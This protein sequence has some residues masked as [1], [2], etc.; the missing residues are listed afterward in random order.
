MNRISPLFQKIIIL[1]SLICF[2]I[3]WGGTF[4]IA[5]KDF[6]TQLLPSG[7]RVLL[8]VL[9]VILLL[10]ALLT[11][12][13]HFDSCSDGRLLC[14]SIIMFAA[15]III[16]LVLIHEFRIIPIND[17]HSIMD[18]A[19][20]MARSGEKPMSTESIYTNYFSKYS[21][22][23][24][25]ALF[26]MGI[27]RTMDQIGVTD[28]YSPLILLNMFFILSGILFTWLIARKTFGLRAAAK[29][30]LLCM[31]NPVY[32]L[33]VFWVYSNTLSIPFMM[34]LIYIALCLYSAKNFPARCI[35]CIAGAIITV[36]GFK[37]RPTTVI[38]VIALIVCFLFYILK[39]RKELFQWIGVF[40]IGLAAAGLLYIGIGKMCD[41]YFYTVSEGN[42]PITH[43]LMMG[44]HDEGRYNLS[45]DS[46]T[47]SLKTAEEK[48]EATLSRTLQNYQELGVKGM[49]KLIPQKMITTW[50]D[51]YF[52][53]E[54]RLNQNMNYSV[55][56]S[57]LVT[58]KS[59]LFHLYCQSFW[60]VS[61][62]LV[63]ICCLNQLWHAFVKKETTP[64][65]SFLFI[66]SLFGS[67]LFY[68]FWE[69]KEAYAIPFLPLFYLLSVQGE[70]PLQNFCKETMPRL[71]CAPRIRYTLK[72]IGI[73]LILL[74]GLLGIHLYQQ[75]S[76]Y[77]VIHN[78]Y[79]IRCNYDTWME[80]INIR[81]GDSL[82]QEF[83]PEEKFNNIVLRAVSETKD[84]KNDCRYTL[85]LT[86]D[87]GNTVYTATITAADI[88]NNHMISLSTGLLPAGAYCLT[89]T[90]ESGDYGD[91]IFLTRKGICLDTYD[92]DF[93][94]NEEKQGSD[95]YMR[96]RH[97]FTAPYCKSLTAAI[98][99]FGG[100]L[101]GIG[102]L[103]RFG[104]A[105]IKEA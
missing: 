51:G 62:M 34:C 96:V 103:W 25:L 85:S 26:F 59:D 19:L 100:W 95:L 33:M 46:F 75:L 102:I 63:I 45:D 80:M 64:T 36:I 67:I 22:N 55:L 68:C 81:N 8:L 88:K 92:G 28:M 79:S 7:H 53:M 84:E 20:F 56:Y 47:F 87:S 72:G 15:M 52:A 41:S 1:L 39:H 18:Q 97:K 37:L 14:Y 73:L 10:L 17:S 60:L 101:I 29:V 13:R 4:T 32:Y 38:P 21:N 16:F 76:N 40:A 44:S 99:C 49:L 57:W 66:L 71:L 48:K 105:Y 30:L 90:K 2:L 89:L 23:Y 3:I 93:Y 50:S 74:C 98:L 24:V 35:L 61:V 78:N 65:V 82:I 91:L 86:N 12:F 42:Y 70:A 27:Y 6:F 43:W 11:I 58:E 69:V 83:N 77:E 104:A 31:L 9:A 54:K 94:I 5:Q